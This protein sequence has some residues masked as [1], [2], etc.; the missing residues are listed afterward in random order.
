LAHRF[1]WLKAGVLILLIILFFLIIN[2][3]F[4]ENNKLLQERVFWQ[5]KASAF[6]DLYNQAQAENKL[7]RTV[8]GE[9]L[10][11]TGVKLESARFL[12]GNGSNLSYSLSVEVKNTTRQN[13]EAANGFILF[14]LVKQRARSISDLAWRWFTLPELGA[15]ESKTIRI[16]GTLSASPKE[17]MCIFANILGE[18]GLAKARVVLPDRL[19]TPQPPSPKKT[20]KERPKQEIPKKEPPKEAPKQVMPQ[21]ISKQET[22]PE[23]SQGDK[24]KAETAIEESKQEQVSKEEESAPASPPVSSAADPVTA[25]SETNSGIDAHRQ[26]E[27]ETGGTGANTNSGPSNDEGALQQ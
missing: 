13:Q 5:E 8:V 4:A 7:L 24:A 3:F 12:P 22:P 14:S 25:D 23:N 17:E 21:E 16:S 2:G 26:E 27:A 20:P 11:V 15:G 19:V 10:V 9:G 1:T 6:E 18:P